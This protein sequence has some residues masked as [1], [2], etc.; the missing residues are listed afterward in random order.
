MAD[1]NLSDLTPEVTR[2]HRATDSIRAMTDEVAEGLQPAPQTL[3]A[4]LRR[5]AMQAPLHSLAVAFLL[6]LLLARRR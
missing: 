4:Q 2:V 3:S 1:P 6:G 5:A